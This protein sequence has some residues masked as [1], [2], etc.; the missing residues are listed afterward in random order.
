MSDIAAQILVYIIYSIKAYHGKK[1]EEQLKLEKEKLSNILD[2]TA[3]PMINN[4]VS[5]G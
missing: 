3:Q 1:S 4:D 2:N 5:V